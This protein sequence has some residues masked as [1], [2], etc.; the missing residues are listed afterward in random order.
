M[1]LIDTLEPDTTLVGVTFG[2][3]SSSALLPK[4]L[5]DRLPAFGGANQGTSSLLS[6]L[7][8]LS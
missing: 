5:K 7:L 2:G 6:I 1:Q 8:E 3:Q 4:I